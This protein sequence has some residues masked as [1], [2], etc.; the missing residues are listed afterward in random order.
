MPHDGGDDGDGD[1]RH[2][3]RAR[4]D[5]QAESWLAHTDATAVKIEAQRLIAGPR[6]GGADFL[7]VASPLCRVLWSFMRKDSPTIGTKWAWCTRRSSTALA[8]TASGKISAQD[9]KLLLLVTMMLAR[10]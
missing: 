10:S 2:S 7:A 3:E 9:S 4:A 5:E 1:R 6:A 8:I